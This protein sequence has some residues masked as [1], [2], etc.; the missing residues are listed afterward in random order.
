MQRETPSFEA[1]LH[2]LMNLGV[3]LYPTAPESRIRELRDDLTQIQERC[4]SVKNSIK[5]RQFMFYI[6][7][8]GT[9]IFFSFPLMGWCIL[10]LLCPPLSCPNYLWP[11]FNT[12]YR[13]VISHFCHFLFLQTK[14]AGS[15]FITFRA[16]WSSTADYVPNQWKLPVELKDIFPGWC[17]W[18]GGCNQYA[19]GPL[20]VLFFSC[21]HIDI[22]W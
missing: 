19:D 10:L 15:P 12:L 13:T 18:S 14:S 4:V 5:H 16:V 21:N 22:D 1:L 3:C 8:H 2:G 9:Y 6:L 7:L 20:I 11:I 17:N